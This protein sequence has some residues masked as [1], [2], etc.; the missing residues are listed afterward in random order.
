MDAV[1]EM[2]D[3]LRQLRV[4]VP[5]LT[6]TLVASTDGFVLAQDTFGVEP[7]GLAALTA[8]ALGVAHRVADATSCG[9]FRELLLHGAQGY[10]ATYAAG[11]SAVLTL[12]ADD[13]VNAGRLH[14]EGRR[15]GA[16]IAELIGQHGRLDAAAVRRSPPSRAPGPT[17]ADTDAGTAA[18]REPLPVR[19]P[20]PR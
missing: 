20:T 13:R 4:R 5:H 14:L 7:E 2:L 8:A 16:R 18:A 6:G 9:E 15:S 19:R 10:V 1:T 3:E 11:R 17:T 12:L